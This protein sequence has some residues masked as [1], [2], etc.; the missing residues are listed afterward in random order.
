MKEI[1]RIHIAKITYDVE[2]EAKKELD[3]YLKALEAYSEDADIIKDIEVRMTEILSER[4][5]RKN[6]VITHSDVV[7]L[8]E[9]L[10]EPRDFM[11]DGEIAVGPEDDEKMSS[12]ATRKLYRNKDSAVL[13]GVLSGIAAFFNV[14]PLWV[15]LAFIIITIGSFGAAL[16]LYVVL[17]IA[18]PPARTAADKLQMIGQPVTISSI[19]KLNEDEGTRSGGSMDGTLKRILTLFLGLGSIIGALGA[20][21][22]TTLVIVSLA[23]NEYGFILQQHDS[24]GILLAAYIL[25]AIS[26]ALLTIMFIL[27]AYASFTQKLPKRIWISLIIIVIAGLGAFG[28]GIGLAEYK[29][30]Y[31]D[32]KHA[33]NFETQMPTPAGI[34][35]ATSMA[36]DAPGMQVQYVVTADKPKIVVKTLLKDDAIKDKLV[37]AVEN[38]TLTV[39]STQTPSELCTVFLCNT[40]H[41]V[42][43]G[44]A[45][46]EITANKK[47]NV[48]YVA[49][50]QQRLQVKLAESADALISAGTIAHLSIQSGDKAEAGATKNAVIQAVE[51]TLT[52]NSTLEFGTIDSLKISGLQSCQFDDVSYIDLFEIKSGKMTIDNI[53]MDARTTKTTCTNIAVEASED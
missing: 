22:I 1:K 3:S 33:A 26:G 15:R 16:L 27:V 20:G 18:M 30:L 11:S 23:K 35:T 48:D 21:F 36:I 32:S 10:G 53:V 51:A 34:D 24:V 37:F 25:F 46:N 4:G 17:W 42:I 28:T 9:Q 8:R 29:N 12:D 47:S 38:A 45:L 40:P 7:A 31:H 13:G 39:R 6:G 41:V 44:P 2:L 19:R 50:S 52:K 5:I 43:Y 49:G 14:N